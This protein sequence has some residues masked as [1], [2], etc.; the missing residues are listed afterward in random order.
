M[1]QPSQMTETLCPG[2]VTSVQMCLSGNMHGAIWR[3]LNKGFELSR[4]NKGEWGVELCAVNE[5]IKNEI[6]EFMDRSQSL[7]SCQMI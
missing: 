2:S 1:V 3:L 7:L 5:Q 6:Y 4:L